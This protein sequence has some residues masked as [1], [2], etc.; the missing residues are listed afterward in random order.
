MYRNNIISAASAAL[1]TSRKRSWKPLNCSKVRKALSLYRHSYV[2][3]QSHSTLLNKLRLRLSLDRLNAEIY[4]SAC[5]HE[6][7]LSNRIRSNPKLFWSY[8][9]TKTKVSSRISSFLS[10]EGDLVSNP[11]NVA[12]CFGNFFGGVYQYPQCSSFVSPSLVNANF[13]DVQFSPQI[14]HTYIKR[15]PTSTSLDPEGFCY[16]L[17]KRGGFFLAS[18]LSDFF[19]RSL[20]A[21]RIPDSWRSVNV[22]PVHKSGPRDACCNYRP[23]AITSC[24]SRLMEKIISRQLLDYLRNYDLLSPSQHGFLPGRSIE[25]AGVEHLDFITSALD[26]GMCVDVIYLDYSKAFDAVSHPLLISKLS[27][28]GIGGFVLRYPG[29]RIICAIVTLLFLSMALSHHAS[30]LPAV[31]FKDQYLVLSCSLF[32]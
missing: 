1:P 18:K 10:P 16:E 11:Q 21:S 24:I 2:F 12:E 5:R 17:L 4:S 26:K 3:F 9:K 19:S 31:L 30:Q 22:I 13:D 6:S 28:Y 20:R 14:V 7:Y 23:I 8:V 15:L 27:S 29:S 32:L 25:T